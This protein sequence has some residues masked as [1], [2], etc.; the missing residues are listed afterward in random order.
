MKKV[1]EY[2]FSTTTTPLTSYDASKLNVGTLIRKNTGGGA[3]NWV[4]P[5]PIALGRPMEVTGGFAGGFIRA[6][7]R[8]TD[9]A[10][11]FI[12]DGA[13]IATNRRCQLWTYTLSTNTLAYVGFITMTA[14]CATTV[15]TRGFRVNKYTYTTGTATC[16]GGTTAVSFSG[17]TF[18]TD[19]H[20]PGRISFDAGVTWY[21]VASIGGE[22]SIT[23]ALNGPSVSGVPYIYEEYRIAIVIT[24]TTTTTNG[25]L[26]VC[27]GLHPGL[28]TTA[29]TSVALAAGT[30]NLRATYWLADAAV[31]TNT[32]SAGLA[33]DDAT[34]T[35]TSHDC[36]VLNGAATT[37]TIYKYNLRASL[38]GLASGKSTSAFV[39]AT[40]AQAGLNGNISQSFNCVIANAGHGPASGVKA[41]YFLTAARGY[42]ALLS[43][44][45]TGST[46]FVDAQV[47]TE[48][49][50]GL[51]NT[52]ASTSALYSLAYDSN[53]DMFWIGTSGTASSRW[54]FTKWKVDGT[55]LDYIGGSDFKQLDQS[56]VSGETSPTPNILTLPLTVTFWNGVCLMT[57][58][59]AAAATNQLYSIPMDA[60]QSLVGTNAINSRRVI[61]PEISTTDIAKFYRFYTNHAESLGGLELGVSCEPFRWWYRT[62]GISDNSGTWIAGS[63]IGDLSG[64]T[65]STSIQ[66]MF[67]FRI[68][69]QSCVPTRLYGIC[70]SYEDNSTDS[71]YSA[72]VAKS[73]KTL[74]R[75]AWRQTLAWGSSIP[76]MKIIITNLTTPGIIITDN[77][78]AQA[79]GTFE[80]STDGVVWNAWSAVADAVGNYVRYTATTLPSSIV[81][82]AKFLIN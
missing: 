11:L 52:F 8:S 3:S 57:R 12:F 13:A 14:F 15:T 7:Q 39:Y 60:H 10:E 33:T 71:H 80:Y 40:G 32:A 45:T 5:N 41:L 47:L 21:D 62:S 42:F 20:A 77:T 43:N 1:Y 31:I 54:Y 78:T 72:A 81:V 64:I 34:Q 75:F 66:F 37:A 35:T 23:L 9:I 46:T 56:T 18:V 61:T 51:T 25:S 26:F 44:I 22:T 36:Y 17:A 74:N 58:I 67:E 28:F 2:D 4:G 38:S 29:G 68:I 82:S 65:A 59:S 49:P 73:D 27:K 16:A 50:P 53:S 24:A 63:P 30:D 70:Y 76:T 69:G 6:I 79:Y 19:R 48:V 55:P